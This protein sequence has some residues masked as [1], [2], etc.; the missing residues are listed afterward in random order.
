MREWVLG[1]FILISAFLG[2]GAAGICGCSMRHLAAERG[3]VRYWRPS[4][5]GDI[6]M[7]DS[8]APGSATEIDLE[9]DL[10]LEAAGVVEPR[11][12]ITL[13]RQHTFS[14]D[15]SAA[16][17]EG[18]ETP[19]ADLVF[20]GITFPAGTL[21]ESELSADV[22]RGS[23]EVDW[24]R[25][26]DIRLRTGVAGYYVKL[27]GRL[28]GSV[29]GVTYANE[30]ERI[31]IGFPTFAISGEV[32]LHPRL[33]LAG[34]AC[35]LGISEKNYALDLEWYGGL[36]LRKHLL[37]TGGYRSQQIKLDV[38]DNEADLKLSGPAFGILLIF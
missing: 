28:R 7:T 5:S 23:Y 21:V 26:R 20:E 33:E 15:Y 30:S 18:E 3:G 8:G 34:R 36:L 10:G 31:E 19:S 32:R 35:G 13:A 1:R 17:V 27:H 25:T 4:V 11:A 38:S 6:Y 29:G 37:L 14:F 22:F 2:L 24:L 9:D 16:R 12:S